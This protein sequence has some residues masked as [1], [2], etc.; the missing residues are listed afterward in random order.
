[1]NSAFF[2]CESFNQDL[3]NWNLASIKTDLE[4]DVF[5]KCPIKKEYRPKKK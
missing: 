3:S 4:K 5:R 2:G 1:L